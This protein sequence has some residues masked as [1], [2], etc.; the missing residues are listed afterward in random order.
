M[1]SKSK[2]RVI[3]FS[4]L[5][6]A[7]LAF[8][9]MGAG[10]ARAQTPTTVRMVYWTGPESI[11]MG[12][13]VNKYNAT[14]GK[15]DGVQVEMV[16]FGREGFIERQEAIMAAKSAEVDMFWF[17]T[18]F[19]GKYAEALEP[20]ETLLPNAG[21]K[22]I[23]IKAL[24][25]G[26][27]VDGHLLALPT[28]TSI[29]FNYY[30]IDLFEQLMKNE[31]WQAK[32]KEISKAKLGKELSPKMPEE[33]DIDDFK[34][35]ALFFTKSVNPDSPV[36]F[37]TVLQAKNLLYNVMLW[38]G[39]LWGVGGKWFDENNKPQFDTPEFRRAAQV[40]A[41]IQNEKAS[42]A[43]AVNYEYPE[44][45]AA[46][47]SGQVAFFLQWSAAYPEI[48]GTGSMAQGLVGIAPLPG[49]KTHADATGVGLNKYSKNKDASAKWMTYLGTVEAME[50][51]AKAGGVPPVA[52]V[53][54]GLGEE[55][56][57]LPFVA[58]HLSKYGFV[59]TTLAEQ[60]AIYDVLAKNLSAAWAGQIDVDTAAKESQKA[61]E[62]I[63]AAA[64]K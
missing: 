12:E 29:H 39:V 7:A 49:Q 35:A 33:W 20:L 25:D 30:R 19:V 52:E 64:K 56:A 37:G 24:N 34:A 62:D 18:F 42:P 50:I 31:K 43:D 26:Y 9:A 2:T 8:G 46:F 23:F 40:F 5:L 17:G 21:D 11:A 51:Y 41:D 60:T 59:E 44:A 38:N 58:D 48:S 28:D 53:L 10:A 22:G 61:T 36:E 4:F 47:M 6:V 3:L 45:N 55:K 54:N 16:L 15:E 1:V 13:V 14:Q 63:L 57:H 27:T 32:Y